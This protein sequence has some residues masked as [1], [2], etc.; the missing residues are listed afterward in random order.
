MNFS[1]TLDNQGCANSNLILVRFLKN[2]DLVW[3]EFGSVRLEK[4]SVRF[5]YS[6]YFLV[7]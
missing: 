1:L 6:S 3:T 7:M 4:N 2:S 5:G